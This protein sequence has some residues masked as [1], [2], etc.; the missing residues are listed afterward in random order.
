M[1][2]KE[3][4]AVEA[5]C[6]EEGYRGAWVEGI[7]RSIKGE[8][9]QINFKKTVK[10]NGNSQSL[11]EV[12][13]CIRAHGESSVEVSRSD[14]R[15]IPPH[16]QLPFHSLHGVAVEAWETDCWWPGFIV[17]Q[18]TCDGRQLWLVSFPHTHILTAYPLSQLRPAQ[19]W[20]D[21][22]WTLAPPVCF[23]KLSIYLHV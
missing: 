9:F 20:R 22:N 18:V 14:V 7:V 15:P 11:V 21:G 4:M 1:A 13:R 23:L 5:R 17:K 10:A 19:E 3:G 12:K 8:L 16:R 2:M 6:N